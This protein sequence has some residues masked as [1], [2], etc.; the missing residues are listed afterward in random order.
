[1]MTYDHDEIYAGCMLMYPRQSNELKC[2]TATLITKPD[3]SGK[4][5]PVF[6]SGGK[7]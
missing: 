4:F 6:F 5:K 7:S 1:M 2:F 3:A